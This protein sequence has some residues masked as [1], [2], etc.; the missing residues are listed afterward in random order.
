MKI[1]PKCKNEYREGI[2]HCADCGCEL[3]SEGAEKEAQKLIVEA[4]YPVARKALEYLEYCKFK[5]ITMEDPDEKGIVALYCD[6][7]EYKDAVKQVSVLIHE[8]Q[9]KALEEQLANMESADL[10]KMQEAEEL[11]AP[12]SNVYQNYETKAEENKS[13]AISFLIIGAVGSVVV[14]LSWFGLLPF[15]IGGKGNWFSHG[16]MFVFFV[17]FFIVGIISAKNVGKYK[18]LAGKEADAQ[19]ELESYLV[20]QFT[21]EV[22]SAIEADTEEEAYFKRMT[23]MRE[24]VTEAFPA[25]T[26]NAVFVESLLDAHYDKIFG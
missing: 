7:K 15:Y 10:D 26:E 16:V 5:T 24:K 17:I 8:E 13:S 18:V 20:E 11:L 4:P 9:K 23:Y 2:T 6:E 25:E 19:N 1:C 12:P 14:A 22:L 21:L 3:V